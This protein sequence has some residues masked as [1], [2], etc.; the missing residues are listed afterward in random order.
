MHFDEIKFC[1]TIVVYRQVKIVLWF[2]ANI[3]LTVGNNT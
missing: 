3:M 1:V 2:I